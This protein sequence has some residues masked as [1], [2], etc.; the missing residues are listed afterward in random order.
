LGKHAEEGTVEKMVLQQ[1]DGIYQ[2]T[3]REME[4][5]QKIT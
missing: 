3:G 2:Q 4:E 5:G 1:T